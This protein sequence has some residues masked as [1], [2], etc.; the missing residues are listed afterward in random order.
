MRIALSLALGLIALATSATAA[1]DYGK[2]GAPIDPAVSAQLIG[3]WTNPVDKVII[4]ID[5]VDLESGMIHGRE[6]P[7]SGQAQGDEHEL[8]GWVSA[9]APRQGFDTVTPVTFSTTLHEYGTLP[10]WAGF[11]KDGQLVTMHYLVWPVR[12]YSWDHISSF[13]ETWSRL[14]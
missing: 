13:S 8:I 2:R 5:A 6:W 3:R 12:T 7:T 1:P 9:A 11:L 10:I 14:P 4:Q